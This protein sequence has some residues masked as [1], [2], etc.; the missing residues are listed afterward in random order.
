MAITLSD[1]VNGAESG[2]NAY[3]TQGYKAG[4][5]NLGRKEVRAQD[6]IE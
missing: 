5:V 2:L 3:V 4:L 6:V 1:T